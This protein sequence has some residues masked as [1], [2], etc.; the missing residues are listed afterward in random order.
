MLPK[1][2][3]IIEKI[4]LPHADISTM[5]ENLEQQKFTGYIRLD[6]PK[7]SGFIFMNEG[8]TASTVEV[9]DTKVR[10]Q[11]ASRL[12]NRTKKKEVETSSYVLPSHMIKVLALSYTFM[13]LY[14]N[15]EVRKKEFNKILETLEND[16]YTGFMH[17]VSPEKNACLLLE[18]G[19]LLTDNFN[20]DFG[21][22][23]CGSEA[24]NHFLETV[25]KTA[26]TVSVM[27]EKA[28][29]IDSKKR[30][31]REELE[32][33]K[34]L[35]VK[36]DTGFF[37]SGDVA[38]VDENYFKDWGEKPGS[39]ILLEVETPAGNLYKIKGTS[40][41]RL[42]NFINLSEKMAAKLKSAEGEV[43]SVNP[44]KE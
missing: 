39:N 7:Q 44:A 19:K 13:P 8:V 21:E 15:Q 6:F 24:V 3:P 26:A 30:A 4:A 34:Q 42:G 2:V 32:K 28:E 22:V 16:N 37:K 43:L 36:F 10:I 40:G 9:E 31:A 38:R 14:E 20:T 17:V 41:K 35:T 25:G 12:M 5:K 27:A 18:K 1:G 33:I 23:L 29:E 11:S